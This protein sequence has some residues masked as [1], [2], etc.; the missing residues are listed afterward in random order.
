MNSHELRAAL[1]LPSAQQ[2]GSRDVE[3]KR[4]TQGG[5]QFNVFADT[6]MQVVLLNPECTRHAGGGHV[7]ALGLEDN[8]TRLPIF[9]MTQLSSILLRLPLGEFDS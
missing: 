1:Y 4:M 9:P 3:A 5:V 6:R 7:M 8:P 2:S